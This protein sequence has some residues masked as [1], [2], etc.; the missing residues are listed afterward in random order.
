LADVYSART[1]LENTQSQENTV[2]LTRA[3]L[4]H[5]IAVLI[6]KAPAALTL[7]QGE[8]AA[9]VPVFPA[10]VPSHLLLRRPD[11]AAPERTLVH[12]NAQIDVAESAW[13]ASLTLS[14]SYGCESAANATEL[15]A[16]NSVWSFGPSL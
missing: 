8:L 14:G 10:G 2:E 6:G 13:F 1:L 5:E 9:T 4:E 7:A 11:I 12:A 15:R 3:K 16:S